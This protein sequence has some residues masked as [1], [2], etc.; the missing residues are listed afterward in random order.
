ML[1]RA[2][3]RLSRHERRLSSPL[4]LRFFAGVRTRYEHAIKGVSLIDIGANLAHD[5]FDE[6]RDQR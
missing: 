1:R 6:D 5:S 3:S 4:A 2:Y